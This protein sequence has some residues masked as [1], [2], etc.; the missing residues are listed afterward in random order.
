MARLVALLVPCLFAAACARAPGTPPATPAADAGGHHVVIVTVD[1]L[2]PDAITEAD[3]PR[4]ARLVRE[5]AASLAS[6][7]PEPSETLPAH[8]SMATGQTAARHGVRSNRTLAR[9]PDNATLFTAA[10]AAGRRTALLFGKSKLIALAPRGSADVVQGPARGEKDWESGASA[11]LAARFARDYARERFGLAWVHL[12][13]GDMA[14]H[15]AGWMTPP[16]RAGLGEADRALGVVLDAIA[17][18]GLPTTVILTS[19]HGGEGKDHWGKNPADSIVPWI[20]FGPGV[21]A[22]AVIAGSSIVDTGPTAAALL[23]VTLPDVEGKV[24]KECLPG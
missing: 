16:Y 2:R 24:V 8:F 3:T 1:G 9:E 4:L 14:G 6:R 23:G 20:C 19:D 22:G 7:V 21:Q 13:E 17:A 10:R 11:A 15:D 18:S 5:G 12:R